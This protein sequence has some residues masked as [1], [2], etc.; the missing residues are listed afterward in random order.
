MRSDQVE[1]DRLGVETIL[2]ADDEKRRRVGD[3]VV[4][5]ACRDDVT[6]GTAL[7]QRRRPASM[8]APLALVAASER[9][10]RM[11]TTIR[12][13]IGFM[14]GVLAWSEGRRRGKAWMSLCPAGSARH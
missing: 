2:T 7:L 10:V 6:G 3:D 12:F 9:A 8:S 1:R 5:R 13:T 11:A 4:A 14:G